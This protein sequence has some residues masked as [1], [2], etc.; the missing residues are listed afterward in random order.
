MQERIF[1]GN[2]VIDGDL[3]IEDFSYICKGNLTVDGTVIIENGSLVVEG[4][5]I[6]NSSHGKNIFIFDGGIYAK[7]ISVETNIYLSY[8][9]ISTFTDLSCMN[10]YSFKGD[11]FV[12]GNAK[13]GSIRCHNYLVD[14][15][16]DSLGIK[17]ENAVYIMEFSNSLT[18]TAPE[19]FLGGGGD[20][21]G[22][23]IITNYFEFDGHIYNCRRRYR[24][25]K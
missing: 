2:L 13:V 8:G 21:G 7:S 15:K 19:V 17:A 25:V 4:D 24:L 16:N 18:I 5:L 10:I 3:I 9:S 14:G 23:P 12:G 11:I 20:F 22:Y 6:I 1:H